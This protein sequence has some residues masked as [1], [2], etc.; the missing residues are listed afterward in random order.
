[1][2]ANINMLRDDYS[3]DKALIINEIVPDMAQ[4]LATHPTYISTNVY[5]PLKSLRHLQIPEI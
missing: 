3:N 1:M 4:D 5:E 2:T